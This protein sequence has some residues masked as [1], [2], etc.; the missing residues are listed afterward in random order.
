[1]EIIGKLSDNLPKT[2]EKIESAFNECCREKRIVERTNTFV[3]VSKDNY[4][5]FINSALNAL[6]ASKILLE[7]ENYE[8][9]IVPAYSAIFQAGNAVLIKELGRECKD[10]F[11][12]LVS[13]LK[14]KKL[15]L[16]EAGRIS[17]IKCKLSEISDNE[18]SLD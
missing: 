3:E 18:I 4:K 5:E 6:N 8:W 12:L 14:L 10:H 7:K 15:G 2:E 17:E 1:M 16:G 9:A 13:L 11:C